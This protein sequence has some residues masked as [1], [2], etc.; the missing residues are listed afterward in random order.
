MD[1]CIDKVLFK[2]MSN[3]PNDGTETSRT[4]FSLY[5]VDTPIIIV[6]SSR[7]SHHY[8]P[9]MIKDSLQKETYNIGRD[10]CFFRYNCCINQFIT[11]RYTPEII[12]WEC[13]ETDL[14]YSNDNR[15]Q[16]LYPFYNRNDI[17]TKIIN[18]SETE[19]RKVQ[20]QSKLYKYNSIALKIL[21]RSL[22][23][24]KNEDKR[25]GYQP[26]APSRLKTDLTLNIDSIPNEEIDQ[27]KVNQ[28]RT[29]LEQITSN[30][31]KLFIFISPKYKLLDE[32]K[33]NTSL[34]MM[35]KVCNEYNV[36][37]FD[38]RQLTEFYEHPEYYKDATHLNN[39]GA[40][41]YTEIVIEQLK[42]YIYNN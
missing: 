35:R 24:S 28:L 36:P 33:T 8:I 40:E 11:K 18:E 1:I 25:M 4:Y 3:L 15:L 32:S 34:E 21:T 2:L 41:R 14:F 19:K 29:T 20:L 22:I 30:G 37:I 42:P 38:N 9:S 27:T 17:V 5:E 26:L 39:I 6:G 13:S 31:T 7:A 16:S 10:G 23:R 12:I